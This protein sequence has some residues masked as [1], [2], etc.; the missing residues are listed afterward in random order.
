M[1][2][3]DNNSSP[4]EVTTSAENITLNSSSLLNINMS[5]ITKLSSSNYLVW[6]RQV[7]A[8]LDGYELASH[9]DE[10]AALPVPSLTVDNVTT[11]NPAHTL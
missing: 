5:N 3:S 1:A 8:L 7:H 2:H 4:P 11:V 9:L 6:S 10:S